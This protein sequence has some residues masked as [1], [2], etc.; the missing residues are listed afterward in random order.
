[1]HLTIP[2]RHP[3]RYVPPFGC[4]LSY[5]HGRVQQLGSLTNSYVLARTNE[6]RQFES[7]DEI[8]GIWQLSFAKVGQSVETRYSFRLNTKQF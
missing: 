6:I 7:A 8:G 5:I 4:L 2:P 3:T 1:M